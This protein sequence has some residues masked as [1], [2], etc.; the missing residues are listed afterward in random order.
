MLGHTQRNMQANNSSRD[1]TTTDTTNPTRGRKPRRSSGKNKTSMDPAFAARLSELCNL[2]EVFEG[3]TLSARLGLAALAAGGVPQLMARSNM[4]RIKP[5]TA[6]HKS[7]CLVRKHLR[8]VLVGKKAFTAEWA[9]EHLALFCH[10]LMLL[11]GDSDEQRAA[12]RTF[13]E[14]ARGI[15]REQS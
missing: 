2:M 10:R 8:A 7:L 11:I 15:L 13:V 6:A 3:S 1:T 9:R 4:T 14:S 5:V 12:I